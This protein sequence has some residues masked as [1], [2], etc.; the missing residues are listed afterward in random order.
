MFLNIEFSYDWWNRRYGL[1]FNR[2]VY[3]DPDK[4]R[5]QRAVMD[6]ES[7]KR[8]PWYKDLTR[9]MEESA[10]S[11]TSM[12]V[13]PFGHRFIPA[14]FGCEISYADSNPPWAENNILSPEEIDAMPFLTMDEF[15]QDER[16]R[17]IT[18]Q[19]SRAREKYG[20]F[21]AQQ[22]LGSVM[23]TAIYLRGMELFTD[24]AERPDTIHKL[25]AL[26]TNRMTLSH[27]YFSEFDGK[28]S[29]VGVGNC[30]V[31][32]IS[33]AAYADFNRRYDLTMMELAKG[34]GVTFSLH[35]DSDLTK[36]IDVYR[37]FDYLYSFD[38]GFDTD[39]SLFREGFPD[40]ALNICLYTSFLGDRTPDE[41]RKDI[42]KL[43]ADAGDPALTGFSCFDIDDN[44]PDE[45]VTA[46]YEAVHSID[47]F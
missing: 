2:D 10:I 46:L 37:A 18:E 15:R 8:F 11:V 25:F 17:I 14:L 19:A 47:L 24:Y 21:S 41:I 27:E 32:M 7:E 31:C 29:G 3:F 42:Q 1:C 16:V 43:A 13:E 45:N 26:I 4:K 5:A 28:P 34:R 30:S 35:Q 40:T 33:P 39:I 23:N 6:K 38:I 20:W 22:N 9:G 44:I 12:S 36:Y